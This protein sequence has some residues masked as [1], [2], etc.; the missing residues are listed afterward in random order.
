MCVASCCLLIL[1]FSF[2]CSS[3][4]VACPLST[5][6]FPNFFARLTV[7]DGSLDVCLFWLVAFVMFSFLVVLVFAF[8]VVFSCFI[9]C[10]LQVCMC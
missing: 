2:D 1:A 5:L 4:L 9:V 6:L 10:F 8:I 3:V 7:S